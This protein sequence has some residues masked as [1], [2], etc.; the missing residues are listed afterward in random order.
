MN[1]VLL[2]DDD[3]IA[4]IGAGEAPTPL[5]SQ[6][7]A[8]LDARHMAVSRNK[9]TVWIG[10]RKT[11]IWSATDRDMDNVADTVEEF[12]RGAGSDLRGGGFRALG[13]AQVTL[14]D[15]ACAV[16]LLHTSKL[17]TADLIWDHV[18]TNNM[19]RPVTP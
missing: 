12:V 17:K 16:Q 13:R 1:R 3:R 8:I 2:I 14:I 9:G 11:T 7:G 6:V 4:A 10:T 19:L 15:S 5:R 18:I